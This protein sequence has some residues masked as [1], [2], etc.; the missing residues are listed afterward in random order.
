MGKYAIILSVFLLGM[1]AIIPQLPLLQSQAATKV[2]GVDVSHWQG[3][4]NWN[5]V[6]SSGYRFAFVKATEGTSYVDP[7]FTT[8]M[9]NGKSA[10]L[11]MGAYHFARPSSNNP[12]AEADHFVNTAGSYIK[13]GYLRPV[14]DL[15]TGTSL[16]WSG[17]S[18]WARRWLQRVE[19]LTGVEPILYVNAYYASNLQSYLTSYDLWIAHYTYNPNTSPNTGKWSTW[20]F[21]QYS[22]KGTV[23]GIS[24]GVDLNV[25]NGDLS[26]LVANAVIGGS[27]SGS[28]TYSHYIV[29]EVTSSSLN[30]R[31]GP[32]TSYSKVGT[33]YSGQRYVAFEQVQSGSL[34]WYKFWFDGEAR[35][36]AATGYTKV[37]PFASVIKV[38]ASTLNV[39]SGPSTGYSIIG[40]V[41]KDEMY[42]KY[43]VSGSWYKIW[44]KGSSRAWVHSAYVTSQSEPSDNYFVFE[45]T[46]SN[47]NVRTG[48]GTGYSKVGTIHAGERYVVIDVVQSGSLTWYKFWFDGNARWAAATGY[49]KVVPFTDVFEV[50]ASNLNVRSGPSTSYSK[51]GTIHAGELYVKYGTSGSWY[52]FWFKGL[53]Y[54]WCHSNYVKNVT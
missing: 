1:L 35:W 22:D 42:V 14:L 52:H 24:G 37:V 32:G 46:T 19:Q 45:V 17:L 21:W 7:K 44:F 9:Q 30:V 20:M 6:Y 18:D 29:F 50:T 49:T 15:E 51:I 26:T 33:I 43:S 8:N 53:T 28:T 11:Y 16:G 27:G 40:Q 4:I 34:T 2:N 48:P 54:A 36:A 38:T 5:S 3:S 25:F 12:E 13:D 10:G 39:R 41:H 31:T 23:S 47:L